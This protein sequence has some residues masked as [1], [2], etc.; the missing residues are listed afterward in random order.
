[1]S[2]HHCLPG[3]ASTGSLESGVTAR[4]WTLPGS[5]KWNTGNLTGEQPNCKGKHSQVGSL[6]LYVPHNTA[7]LTLYIF[8]RV[9]MSPEFFC[10]SCFMLVNRCPYLYFAHWTSFLGQPS[11]SHPQAAASGFSPATL[12]SHSQHQLDFWL[13]SL[14][15][16]SPE[17]PGEDDSSPWALPLP[18]ESCME[19]KA[20]GVSLSQPWPLLSFSE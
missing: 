18:W 8:L 1:M 17:Q 10:I 5:L 16:N 13:L 20:H 2:P 3:C 15:A 6:S 9:Q 14:P 11:E 7:L 4:P 19:L 12:A